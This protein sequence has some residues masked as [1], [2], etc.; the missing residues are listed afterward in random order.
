MKRSIIA[1]AMTAALAA[2]AFA[3]EKAPETFGFQQELSA[4]LQDMSGTQLGT[5]TIGDLEKVAGRVSIV[6]QKIR[7]V[8][9]A[10][11]ASFVFP[12]AGQFM[13][14]DT[15][16]GSLFLAGDVAIMAGTLLGAYF[17]LPSNVQFSRLDY[18]NTSLGS[19]RTAWESNSITNYLP[20]IGVLAG[21]M[22][23][24]AI[25]GHFSSVDAE[26]RARANIAEGKVTFTPNLD[27]MG[28]GFGMGM[29]MRMSY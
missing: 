21:G 19:I 26:S 27:V 11:R 2:A 13:T 29:G 12:G 3:Q 8:Q 22:I 16:G 1:L 20:S 10:R 24:K 4:E 15:L 14:G 6:V 9:K 17:L 7:Y 18:L 5:L 28:P 23:L 25:L